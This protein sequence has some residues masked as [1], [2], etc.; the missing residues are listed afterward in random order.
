MLSARQ[1]VGF[2]RMYEMEEK[3]KNSWKVW[4]LRYVMPKAICILVSFVASFPDSFSPCFVFCFFQCHQL[5][6]FSKGARSSGAAAPAP[7][8]VR[9]LGIRE[10]ALAV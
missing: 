5:S 6:W 3:F 8:A 1:A 4:C 2:R 9:N 10:A 7:A